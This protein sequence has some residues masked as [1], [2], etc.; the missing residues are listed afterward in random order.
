MTAVGEL[1]LTDF[2]GG[3]AR[4]EPAKLRPS[5]VIGPPAIFGDRVPFV[6]VVPLTTT[7]RELPLHVEI[8]SSPTTG[9]DETSYAQCEL[10]RSVGRPRMMYRLGVAPVDAFVA[11]DRAVRTLLDH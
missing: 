2:G 1:W 3:N 4:G 5:L 11:V 8:E 9:L 10:I 6:I 7:R